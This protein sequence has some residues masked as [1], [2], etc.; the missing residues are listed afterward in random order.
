MF[1]LGLSELLIIGALVLLLFGAKRLPTI[2]TAL[3][4]GIRNFQKGLSANNKKGESN[5]TDEMEK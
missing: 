3:A 5:N 2:G 1:G 4:Q